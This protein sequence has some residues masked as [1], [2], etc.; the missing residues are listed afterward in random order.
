MVEPAVHVRPF[1]EPDLVLLERDAND[2][3]FSIPFEWRGFRS[4]RAERRRWEEDEFLGA[5]PYRLVVADAEDLALGWVDWRDPRQFGRPGL[6]WELGITIAPEH[7]GRGVGTAAQRRLI[8]YLFE[9]TPAH[10]L[11]AHTE[12]ENLAEQRALEKCGFRREAVHRSV[13]MRDGLWRDAVSYALLRTETERAPEAND[14]G[15]AG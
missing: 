1:R 6:A 12:F 9:T 4:F 8:A 15:S 10:R 11:I 3:E 13:G 2:R 5:E 14:P 7:R